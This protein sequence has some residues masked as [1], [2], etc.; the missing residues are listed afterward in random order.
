MHALLDA[1]S[2]SRAAVAGGSAVL[3]PPRA[4][5]GTRGRCSCASPY[6]D[7]R[8]LIDPMA[9][10]PTGRT[11][12]DAWV[13]DLEGRLLA[14]QLSAAATSTRCCT[15]LDV[16][17]GREVEPPIDRCR[18]SVVAW[19]PGG[20]EFVFVRMVD[21]DEVPAGRAGLPPPHLAAP[22]RHPDRARTS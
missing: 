16:A 3:H 9:I 18:Y 15:S 20:A 14:Y 6:G 12:L 19:L 7:E 10:D 11:T 2:V 17:T 8:V 5:A 21:E 4:R 13:P 22:R 1:G